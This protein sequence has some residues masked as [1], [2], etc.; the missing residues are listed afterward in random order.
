MRDSTGTGLCWDKGL[1]Y[2]LSSLRAKAKQSSNK[3][4]KKVCEDLIE[5]K[6]AK[7]A[8]KAD[9]SEGSDLDIVVKGI[10]KVYQVVR[11]MS[12]LSDQVR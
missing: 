3:D 5:Q 2:S 4:G 12:G 9:Y 10:I 8:H 6:R 1:I 11:V 7:Y